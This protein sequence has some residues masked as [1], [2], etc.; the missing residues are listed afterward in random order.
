MGSLRYFIYSG[1]TRSFLCVGR[2]VALGSSAPFDGVS[3]GGTEL[4]ADLLQA[5]DWQ[6]VPLQPGPDILALEAAEDDCP[7]NGK[8]GV[9]LSIHG[10]C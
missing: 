10:G 7:A 6:L 2:S 4:Q 3:R 5:V 1:A 8:G 9:L